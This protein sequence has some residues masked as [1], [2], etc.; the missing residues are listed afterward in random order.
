MTEPDFDLLRMKN[1][2]PKDHCSS[3]PLMMKKIG[4]KL[5]TGLEPVT[6]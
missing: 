5:M 3:T 2:T 1:A 4:K 6:Y